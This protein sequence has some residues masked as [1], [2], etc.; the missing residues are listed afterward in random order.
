MNELNGAAIFEQ[1]C[2]PDAK[3]A[4]ESATKVRLIGEARAHRRFS[5]GELI[6]HNPA[7]V[8]F[9]AR[10]AHELC[11]R[12]SNLTREEVTGPLWR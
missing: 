6:A 2:R 11:K 8:R 9:Q 1:T 12:R 10:P 3:C 7:N 4:F 5:Q